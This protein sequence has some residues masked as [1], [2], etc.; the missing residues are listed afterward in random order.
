MDEAEDKPPPGLPTVVTINSNYDNAL[1][2]RSGVPSDKD[3]ESCLQS[4][5]GSQTWYMLARLPANCECHGCE[6]SCPQSAASSNR[7]GSS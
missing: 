3:F 5:A 2:K 6:C 4:L 7:I 1:I